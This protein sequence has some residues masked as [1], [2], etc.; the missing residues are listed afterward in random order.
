MVAWGPGPRPG[1]ARLYYT[2]MGGPY[3]YHFEVS[4]S[5][6]EGRTWHL[7]FTANHTR[8]WAIGIEDMVIDTNPAS[9]NY[10]T[11]Y[12]A[13]NWPKD[14]ARG[15]GM[16]VVASGDYGH[17]FADT[18]IPKLSA[19]SG[20][21]DAWRIGYKLTTAPDGSAYVAGYQLDMK[22]W[23]S[24]S[25]FWKGSTSNVGRIA[26]GVARLSFDRRARKLSH[27]PNVLATRLPETAWNLGWTPALKGVNVGLAEPSWATGLVVDAGGRIYYAVAGD[28]RIRIV[29]SDDRGRTWRLSYVPQAPPAGGKRQRSMRPDLVVGEGFLAVIFHTVDASG[30]SRS[31]G[32]AVAMSF[33]R[34]AS[35][36]GPRPVNGHRWRIKPIIATYNGPGLRD[37]AACLPTAGRSTSRMAMGVMGS[38][39]RSARV[40]ARRSCRPRR[41]RLRSRPRSRLRRR[42]CCRRPAQSRPRQR[43]R[44]VRPRIPPL[45][46]HNPDAC[47]HCASANCAHRSASARSY[48][49]S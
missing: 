7:G 42:P 26:F 40:S 10:G 16:H 39:R 12:L 2:A 24:S 34:G 22:V 44:R 49:H 25:P 19:P 47:A 15:D 5:D 13:Y 6:N 29:T 32:N 17:T 31:A 20:Y 38:R 3:P 33:D 48:D 28:G 18:E 41:P 9:P 43:R 4:Y 30:T 35:W 46:P 27:G 14:P 23:R 36:V 11:L 8:G 45:R 21:P 37:R 1:T